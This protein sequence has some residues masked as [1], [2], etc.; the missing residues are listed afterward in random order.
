MYSFSLISYHW[1]IGA[2]FSEELH[3][4]TSIFM[5]WIS[6]QLRSFN[7]VIQSAW[8]PKFYLIKRESSCKLHC[9]LPVSHLCLTGH[10][11]D[12]S[13]SAKSTC[14]L[15]LILQPQSFLWNGK[16][17]YVASPGKVAVGGQIWVDQLCKCITVLGTPNTVLVSDASY[18]YQWQKYFL[19]FQAHWFFFFLM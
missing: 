13:N 4:Q 10:K 7:K 6:L 12:I 8:T 17:S 14:V 3:S 18:P 11:W 15:F 9:Q 2:L 1:A 5:K 19:V 16:V